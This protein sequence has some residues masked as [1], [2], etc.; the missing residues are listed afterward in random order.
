MHFEVPRVRMHSFREFAQHYLMIVLSILT[1]LGLEQWIESTHH[2]H[3][4]EYASM[5]IEMELRGTLNDIQSSLAVNAEKLKPLKALNEAITND[6]RNGVPDAQVNQHI[7]RLKN[8]F[9]LS[10]SW[11]AFASQA[12]DVAVANQSATWIDTGRLRKYSAAYAAQ[13]E[14]TSWV[15]HDAT[16]ALDGPRMVAL[17][18]RIKLGK[19]VDPLEFLSVLQQMVNTSTEMANHLEETAEPIKAA[20]GQSRH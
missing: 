3:A 18:T 11:P 2:R 13:R 5:Q 10:V 4:A 14:T 7:Q 8:D 9:I 17:R 12:W 6:V 20:L 16:L 1:A 19:D 15:G